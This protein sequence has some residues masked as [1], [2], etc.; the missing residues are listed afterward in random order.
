MNLSVIRTI[1]LKAVEKASF[2]CVEIQKQLV[3]LDTITKKDQ[4]PVT[5]ADYTVQALVIYEL[6]KE[7]KNHKEIDYPIIAEEDSNTLST[8]QD[9]QSK[10]L[11]YFN[12]YTKEN[13]S[14]EQ[15]SQLLDGSKSD[16]ATKKASNRWWTLDPID[17]T[18]GF[19]RND[20]YAIALA[21]MEHNKPVL[22][23]LGCPSLPVVSMKDTSEKGCVFVALKGCGSFMKSLS[24]L[25]KEIPISVSSQS[26]QT[27][28]I[29]TESYVSRGFGHELNSKISS[30]MGV[31]QEALKIDSQ[32]KYA[33]V[34]RGES[35][36]YLRLTDVNYKE[37][38]WDHAS[39]HIIVE[40]AGGVVTDYKGQE[41]N[42]SLNSEKLIEN[43]GILCSNKKLYPFVKDAIDK[44]IQL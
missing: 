6:M 4:S 43:V 1:A 19:L 7:F 12:H 25:D 28:A 38:I 23:V 17:G 22:G 32:C 2:A 37:C 30:H 29:F 8:Q 21:L 34:A 44:S 10:V 18:L 13:Y 5:V 39:G 15:L 41:L 26:D 16:L 33:M 3:S 14:P 20:Q 35:D 9:V 36:V 40:E 31:N 11:S 42:Y 27:K 24:N